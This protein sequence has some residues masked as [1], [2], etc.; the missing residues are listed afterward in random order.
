MT[1]AAENVQ[2]G[3]LSVGSGVSL[4]L[5]IEGC[6]PVDAVLTVNGNMTNAGT[7]NLENLGNACGGTA[8]VV[9]ASGSTL[10]NT[11]TIAT[12]GCCRGD[13][14]LTGS[15]TNEGTINVNFEQA[16]CTGQ[17]GFL[18]L[19]GAGSLFDNEGAL[20]IAS[21]MEV[22]VPGG[23]GMEFR[24][25]T[26]GSITAN[27]GGE[28]APQFVM[29]SGNTF[30]EGAGTTTGNPVLING[31]AT[32]HFSG[33]GASSFD[34]RGDGGTNTISGSTIASGQTVTLNIHGCG[35]VS[36]VADLAGSMT[37]AGTIN[38]GNADNGCGGTA[39]LVIPS[40]D[41]LTNT[42]TIATTGCCRGDRQLTGSV[43]NE[44]TINVNFEQACCISAVGVLYLDGAGSLFDNQGAL[45]IADGMNLINV[46]ETLVV[47]PGGTFT[48]VGSGTYTQQS[49]ATL[50]VTVDATNT[51]FTAISGG[52]TNLAGT[53]RVTTVGIPAG[54][55]S[56]PII[57]GVSRL[58]TFA[59]DDFGS[60]NYT[61]EYFGT[62]VT[63]V[64]P[65]AV[66]A[67]PTIS[68]SFALSSIPV[69]GTTSLGFTIT[70]PNAGTGL[71]GVGFTDTLPAG[72]VVATPN[73]LTGSCGG[74][75]I[76]ATAGS[77]G[78]S[79]SGAALVASASCT[80]SVNVTGTTVGVNVN[81]T[82]VVTSMQGGNGNTASASVTVVTPPPGTAS[83]LVF[84]TEPGD[85]VAGRGLSPQP[86]VTIINPP[87]GDLIA[88]SITP[89][90]GTP[91]AKVTCATNPAAAVNA[92]AAFVG[93]SVD[94][95]GT[96]YT[97]TA[98]D[99][100]DGATATS[101]P[102]D[103]GGASPIFGP[104][105]IGT[106]ITVSQAEFPARGSA[107]AVVLARSDFF[108]D[109][110]AG[111]PLAAKIDGPLLI[112]PGDS[113][114]PPFGLD[115]RVLA[116]IERVLPA[117]GKVYVLGGPQALSPSIDEQLSTAGY[118]VQRVAGANEFATAVAIANQLGN[119]STIFE[120]TGLNFPDALA[121]VPAA[122]HAD[123]AI[124][125]TNG[126]TQAPETATDLAAHPPATRYVIG[127]P[128]AA[129]QDPAA[130][131]V[132]G[133][134]EFGTSAAVATRFFPHASIFGVATGLNYPDALTGGVYMATGGRLGP[135]LLVTTHAPLPPTITTYLATLAPSTQGHVFG[136]PLAVGDDVLTALDAAIG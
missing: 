92:M 8:Q 18:Y 35:V 103:V 114:S 71:T 66:T 135:V 21:G 101:T 126:T 5:Q 12:T 56:W 133:A 16:C 45:N 77:G 99:T 60:T 51:T 24:N 88:L 57:A 39:Q 13:R 85:G 69:G 19:D 42:G 50:G 107:K 87:G 112:T 82:S 33:S 26:G 32:L 75:T 6:S 17:T 37:N 121:A 118:V 53:L 14:Q 86:V 113:I 74:G 31:G 116:E 130:T 89:G 119:P 63:L 65:A 54:G 36:S 28:N 11:G 40:A 81:T 68:K 120:A 62:G 109:A 48:L 125:L 20:N 134:D 73:G 104:D 96:G 122:I 78:I 46:D 1:I 83:S 93:C 27:N 129:Y 2:A 4:T 94:R 59:T 58:G 128:L 47:E 3:T 34:L 25:D 111:G 124:L 84:S 123:G 100:T 29:E 131:P 127:G 106:A 61:V 90:T 110:L 10:T 98:V 30:T 76:T 55:S 132:Y 136:G 72:L 105:A 108:S 52:Y 91:G 117:G 49:G 7:V 23:T 43:T 115:A 9:I 102:F 95:P 67:P 44:G 70:N 41:T 64:A 80:F 38:L 15:V 22:N 79:L 97:L